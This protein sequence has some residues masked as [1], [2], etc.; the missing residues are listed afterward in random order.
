LTSWLTTDFEMPS[1]SPAARM[2]PVSTIFIKSEIVL[3]RSTAGL[4]RMTTDHFCRPI[5]AQS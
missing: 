3:K 5:I 2:L 4:P 1:A